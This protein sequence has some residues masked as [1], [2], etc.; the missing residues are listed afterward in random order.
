M[1][2]SFIG[3]LWRFLCRRPTTVLYLLLLGGAISAWLVQ[4]VISYE[5]VINRPSLFLGNDTSPAVYIVGAAELKHP[6]EDVLGLSQFEADVFDGQDFLEVYLPLTRKAA[7]RIYG[8]QTEANLLH[9]M[10][11]FEKSTIREYIGLGNAFSALWMKSG[12]LVEAESLLEAQAIARSIT[13][14]FPHSNKDVIFQA[15][16]LPTGVPVHL[17]HLPF[18]EAGLQQASVAVNGDFASQYI[19]DTVKH[20][21]YGIEPIEARNFSLILFAKRM[22]HKKEAEGVSIDQILFGNRGNK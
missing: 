14:S 13:D 4:S 17:V 8:K 21:M 1:L 18:S 10:F 9:G 15:K 3:S 20:G 2:I 19:Q 22:H 12:F 11:Y 5:I 16:A 6:F 7:R